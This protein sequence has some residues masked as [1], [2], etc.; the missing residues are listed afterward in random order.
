MLI[1]LPLLF[2]CIWRSLRYRGR[3]TRAAH[4]DLA[5]RAESRVAMAISFSASDRAISGSKCS[6]SAY[7]A[8]SGGTREQATPSLHRFADSSSECAYFGNGLSDGVYCLTPGELNSWFESEA[9]SALS[10]MRDFELR[11]INLSHF[12]RDNREK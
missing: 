5:V 8:T 12:W 9:V 10:Q 6:C 2:S 7:L 1:S 11:K 4:L 3:R